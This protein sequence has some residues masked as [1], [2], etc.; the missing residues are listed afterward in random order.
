[1]KKDSAAIL[2]KVDSTDKK[3]KSKRAQTARVNRDG[4]KIKFADEEKNKEALK[5]ATKKKP[6]LD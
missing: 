3:A 2:K 4:N 6:K 1:M 5:T